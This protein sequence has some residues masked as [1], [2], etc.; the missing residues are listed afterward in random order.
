MMLAELA[1]PKRMVAEQDEFDGASAVEELDAPA[2]SA[3]RPLP[4]LLL[5]RRPPGIM[6]SA[7]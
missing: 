2:A 3:L 7:A 5:Q 4:T 6:P 1:N